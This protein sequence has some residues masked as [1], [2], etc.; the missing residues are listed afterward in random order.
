MA[1][2]A[3]SAFTAPVLLTRAEQEAER[4]RRI[5]E[6]Q[7]TAEQAALVEQFGRA[8]LADHVYSVRMAKAAN[9]VLDRRAAAAELATPGHDTTGPGL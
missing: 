2:L 5:A 1:G 6:F 4:R 8:I 3:L 7:P 9:V